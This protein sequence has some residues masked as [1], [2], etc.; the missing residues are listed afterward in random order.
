MDAQRKEDGSRISEEK[1]SKVFHSA[2]LL[3]TISKI[4]DGTYLEVNEMFEKVS[5]FSKEEAIGKTSVELGWISEKDRIQLADILKRDG[6]VSNM[7]LALRAKNGNEIDC[8]Y[9]G[10]II[11]V[12]GKNVLLSIAL[13]ITEKRRAEKEVKRME[14]EERVILDSV[15]AWIFYKDTENRFVRVN[16]AF[17][18]AMKMSKED[19]EG[20]SMFDLYPKEQAENFWKDDK[21]VMVSGEPRENIIEPMESPSGKVWVK[22]DKI[23]LRDEDGEI[24]GIVGFSVDVT[25]EREAEK[26]L[27]RYKILYETSADAIMTLEPPEWRFTSGNPATIKMFNT[28][29]E[30]EFISLGPGDL[31]PE[32]QPDGQLSVD[33]SKQMIE[34]AMK[35]GSIFFEWIHKRY[36]GDDFPATVLL[37]KIK[38]DGEELLQATVRDISVQKKAEEDVGNKLAEIEK[39]NKLMI[40]RELKMVELKNEIAE[41]KGER[42]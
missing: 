13:D 25:R 7:E 33:K 9:S 18:T 3:M 10:E 1:F 14:L 22:T 41:L 29:D 21:L 23:P 5:G 31:S 15:P 28:Q 8:L 26:I 38:P 30:K 36:N 35:E 27:E 20:K 37:T 42:N 34:K 12:E 16:K 4:E 40:G 11:E 32:R 24:I 6:E 39:M 17:A 2:P 19:L